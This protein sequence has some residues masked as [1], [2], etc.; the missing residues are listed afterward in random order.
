MCFTRPQ[1]LRQTSALIAQIQE[2]GEDLQSACQALSRI[3]FTPDGHLSSAEEDTGVFAKA[4][5]IRFDS[6]LL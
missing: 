3:S 1:A 4:C 2:V 5:A 6:T